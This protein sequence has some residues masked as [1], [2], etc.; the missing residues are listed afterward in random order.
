MTRGR[1]PYTDPR[2]Q[3]N[4]QI[5][6]S[7]LEKM[8]KKLTD[9]GLGKKPHGAL[10]KYIE[11]LIRRDLQAPDIPITIVSDPFI[12]EGEVHVFNREATWVKAVINC[13]LENTS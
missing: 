3:R 13:D 2:I 11:G 9:P 7:L 5:P 6:K 1:K 8:E 10:S 4:V 12:P